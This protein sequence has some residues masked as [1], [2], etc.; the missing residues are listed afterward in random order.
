MTDLLLQ[1]EPQI[2]DIEAIIRDSFPTSVD[3]DIDMTGYVVTAAVDKNDGTSVSFAVD[4]TD[5][6]AG[7]FSLNLTAVQMATIGLGT[8]HWYCAWS[9]TA[10]EEA[11]T[12]FAGKF[13][14]TSYGT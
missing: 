14:V 9:I 11:R 12:A 7:Q 13:T 2:I 1:R 6:S 10:T 4:A 3:F 5:L 8:H